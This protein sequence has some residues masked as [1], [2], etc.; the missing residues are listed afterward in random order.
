MSFDASQ[1]QRAPDQ[2][3]R[4]T[5][6]GGPGSEMDDRR[7]PRSYTLG[8][9]PQSSP[10]NHL[11]D[12]LSRSYTVNGL[13]IQFTPGDH[14]SRAQNTSPPEP[15]EPKHSA[16]YNEPRIETAQVPFGTDASPNPGHAADESTMTIAR[17]YSGDTEAEAQRKDESSKHWKIWCLVAIVITLAISLPVGWALRVQDFSVPTPTDSAMVSIFLV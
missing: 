13:P 12:D 15:Y 8:D 16:T 9:L 1:G 5:S 10:R 4:Q 17:K 3:I 6:L 7:P 2:A 14:P 11:V